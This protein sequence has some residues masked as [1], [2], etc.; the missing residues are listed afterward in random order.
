M[1]V[2]SP[3][4]V[5]G[6]PIEKVSFVAR[7]ER[8]E[9][10]TYDQYSLPGHHLNV[11][12]RGR[13]HVECNGRT[14]ELSRGSVIWFHETEQCRG[15][16]VEA[17]WVYYTLNFVAP[18]LPP[19]NFEHRCLQLPG[20]EALRQFERLLEAWQDVSVPHLVRGLRVQSRLL[21]ILATLITPPQQEIQ[22]DTEASLWWQVEMELR[23]N[24]TRP[25][26]LRMMS[27]LANRSRATITR[28]CQRAVGMS[29]LK[30]VKQI[31]LSMAHGLVILSNLTISEIAARVGYGRVHELSR[32]YHKQF[33]VTPTEHREQYPKTYQREF[34]LPLIPNR[35]DR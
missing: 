20:K 35:E 2:R 5:E 1:A 32:D 13:V 17:P 23:R 6:F 10:F 28:S 29:P 14:Y 21:E 22:Y 26:D 12:K 30:R 4:I 7:M 31:R 9:G 3:T 25:I 27:R 18:S 11:V 8:G 33:N 19:P 34:G 16:V 24:L 15:R